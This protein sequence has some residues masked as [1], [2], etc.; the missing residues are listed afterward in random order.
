MTTIHPI[1]L[2]LSNAYL[3]IGR[4]PVLVDS[5]APGDE[6]RLLAALAHHGVTPADLALIVHTHGHVD[7]AGTSAALRQQGAGP[8]L[9]HEH[10]SGYVK[11]GSNGP[12]PPTSLNGRIMR[13]LVDKPFPPFEP[14]LA[15]TGEL[16]LT[17]YGI[18]GRL[19]HTP[20]HTAG[21]LTLMLDDGAAIAGD[22]LMGGFLGGALAPHRP[23]LHYFAENLPAVH[24]S[25][26]RLLVDHRPHTLFVG[27]GG[28]LQTARI[29]LTAVSH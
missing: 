12:L 14:D 19:L 29:Q 22:L 23:R 26:R 3:V 2:K 6:N 17:D 24:T 7:H 13:P 8:L 27:H 5:G 11:S 18:D 16:P 4:R 21:S 9:I 10:D 20:G 25:L 15:I 28:P 1:K